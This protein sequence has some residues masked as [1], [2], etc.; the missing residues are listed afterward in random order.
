MTPQIKFCPICQNCLKISRKTQQKF[1]FSLFSSFFPSP[2]E[3]RTRVAHFLEKQG[4]KPQAL[5]V[6]TDPEHKFELALSLGQLDTCYELV[7]GNPSDAKW[8]Q[9]ADLAS[10]QSDFKLATQCYRQA[11]DL[12]GQLLL[13]TSRGDEKGVKQLGKLKKKQKSIFQKLSA[14]KKHKNRQK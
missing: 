7:Q 4:F 3:Q 9:L 11:G 13:A 5:A 2:K 14:S 1:F 6:T 10:K 8:K 12:G